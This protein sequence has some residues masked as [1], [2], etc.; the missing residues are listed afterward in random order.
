MSSRKTLMI[1]GPSEVDPRVLATLPVPVIPHYGADWAEAY[2]RTLENL[3]KIFKTKEQVIIFPGPGN[4]ANELVALNVIEP[5]D[6][7]LNVVNGMFGETLS[8]VIRV[9]G[10]RPV[11]TRAEYGQVVSAAEVERTLDRERDVKAIF[12]VHNETSAGVENPIWDIGR[13]ARKHGVIC[14]ADAISSFGG[15]NIDADDWGIDVCVG[16]GSKCLGGINGAVPIM[17]GKRIWEQV[18][19]RRTPILSRFM[20]LK[21]WKQ[22]FEGWGSLGHPHPTSM[23]TTVI[24]A[25]SE[26]V[27]L[28]LGEGLDKRYRRHY[29][30]SRA[31][32]EGCRKIGLTP[33][34]EEEIRSNT[35]TVIGVPEGSDVKIRDIMEKKFNIMIG[36]GL[37]KLK[38]RSVRIATMG[39]TASPFYVLPTLS[40]LEATLAEIGLPVTEGAA[41][42]EASKVFHAG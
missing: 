1:P 11:E 12:A 7:V 33:L 39:L 36:F 37:S 26:A 19:S 38:G 16:Y 3:K 6:K 13:V 25:M 29:V 40:A 8:D 28:A 17:I 10:G 4:G 23:P 22:F 35:V 14:F 31:L 24:L 9:Y 27:R 41:V 20:S 34:V 15:M 30:A 5:G 2:D 32:R 18:E 21:V 42:A